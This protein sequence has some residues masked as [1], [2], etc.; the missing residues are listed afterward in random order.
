MATSMGREAS[1][2][3]VLS[4]FE[5]SRAG[6]GWRPGRRL[7]LNGGCALGIPRRSLTKSKRVPSDIQ[8]VQ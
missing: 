8:S 7:L 2:G 4:R 6:L 3:E 1:M 5:L